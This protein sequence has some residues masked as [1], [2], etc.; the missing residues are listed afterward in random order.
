ML[1]RLR[2]L[3]A[4][5][6]AQTADLQK[7][8]TRFKSDPYYRALQNRITGYVTNEIG[9]LLNR[10]AAR[11][12]DHAVIGLVVEKLDFRGGG[13]SRRM[14]RIATRTGRKV[15]KPDSKHSPPNT[16]LPSPRCRVRGQAANALAA[17]TR[18]RPTA[19]GARFGCDFCGRTLHADV[20]AAVWSCRDV[21]G[22]PRITP[23][24]ARGR[25]PSNYSTANTENGGDCRQKERSQALQVPWGDPLK[26]FAKRRNQLHESLTV[27]KSTQR[28]L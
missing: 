15:F 26:R 14:N 13:L 18:R 2:E 21:L 1:S 16:A 4:V 8:G 23:A 9:R 24:H 6:T 5:L 17:A 20:N 28:A 12:G 25:T 22:E 3:D 19:K 10:I 7:R 11:D 27:R